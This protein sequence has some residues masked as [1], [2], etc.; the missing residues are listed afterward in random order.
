MG[1]STTPTFRAE[2]KGNNWNF[3][4]FG[5]DCKRNGRPTQANVD[6]Y[7][8]SLNKSFQPGGVNW[9]VSESRGVVAHVSEVRVI[10][11]AGGEVVAVSKA[12]LFEVV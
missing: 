3:E 9:H 11:Q 6:R 8:D 2:V 12:P 4:M 7:R 5:W 1:R 10:R